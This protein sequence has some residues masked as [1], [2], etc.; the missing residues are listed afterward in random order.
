[1]CH[2]GGMWVSCVGS[3]V[4]VMWVS[5]VDV[6]DVQNARVCHGCQFM[7]EMCV[8]WC[9]IRWLSHGVT[10]DGCHKIKG[11][12]ENPGQNR[13]QQRQTYSFGRI[14]RAMVC[15]FVGVSLFLLMSNSVM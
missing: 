2:R 10:S 9:H 5:C 7:E 4:G 3:H 12:S 8:T 13:T 11:K 15:V 14:L 1:M 6:Q